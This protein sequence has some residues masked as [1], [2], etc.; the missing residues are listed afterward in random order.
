M[1]AYTELKEKFNHLQLR[2]LQLFESISR[3]RDELEKQLQNNSRPYV[4]I[5]LV[6][7]GKL[8][9]VELGGPA[10]FCHNKD[11]DP[12]MAMVVSGWFVG[13]SFT[14]KGDYIYQCE[15]RGKTSWYPFMRLVK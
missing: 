4:M 12:K 5:P 10:E 11:F 15:K 3:E 9:K 6:P 8:I 2:T 13:V 1:G 7:G 14:E